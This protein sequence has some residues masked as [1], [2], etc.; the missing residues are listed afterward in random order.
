MSGQEHENH[1]GGE[2]RSGNVK[3]IEDYRPVAAVKKYKEIQIINN[4]KDYKGYK[5]RSTGAEV[6]RKGCKGIAQ[7]QRT[8]TKGPKAR[9]KHKE[10]K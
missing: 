5:G 4:S 6:T 9:Y 7:T 8:S 1:Q 10:R 3:D 2:K